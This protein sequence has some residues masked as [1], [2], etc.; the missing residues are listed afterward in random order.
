MDLVVS[1]KNTSN[2]LTDVR[3]II[4]QTRELA[5]RSVNVAMLQRNW[6]LGKRISEEILQDEDRAEYGSQ[7][8]VQLSK[9]LTQI[10]GKGFTKSYLY[11]Y[12][13]FYKTF[14]N[15]FQSPI[16]QSKLLILFYKI[17]NTEKYGT[18]N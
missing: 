15:I 17:K 14:P 18:D 1:Y 7:V 2:L 13:R 12:V 3:Q 8:I 6:H 11:N 9:E 4:D 10:Y 16:G 5:F